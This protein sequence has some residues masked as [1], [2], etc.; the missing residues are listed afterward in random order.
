MLCVFCMLMFR[1]RHSIC[2]MHRM[3]AV[4]LM[5]GVF[6]FRFRFLYGNECHSA[7]RTLAGFSADDFWMHRTSVELLR[8]VVFGLRERDARGGKRE[9]A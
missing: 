8:A 5:R 1:H 7:F 2:I 4:H 3:F 6:A 9:N